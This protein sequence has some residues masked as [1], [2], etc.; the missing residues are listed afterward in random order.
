[1][2]QIEKIRA[3][4]A[5]ELAKWLVNDADQGNFLMCVCN[6]KNCS[7]ARAIKEAEEKGEDTDLYLPCTDEL[8]IAAAVRYLES[9]VEEK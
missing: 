4:S 3:M 6:E 2:T 9:E 1:M 8:C 5:E 7:N